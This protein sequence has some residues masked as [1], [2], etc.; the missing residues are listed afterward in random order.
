MLTGLITHPGFYGVLAEQDGKIVGSNFLDE[1]TSIAG[2]GPITIATGLQNGNIGKELMMNVI[3][4][5]N[6]KGFAGIRLLQ[7]A[8]NNKSLS[9]YAKLG[10]NVQTALAAM[11]GPPISHKIEGYAVRAALKEDMNACNAVC[12]YVHGHNRSGE[13]SDAIQ[14]GTALVVEHDDSI[15]G[16]STGLAYFGHSVAESNEALKALISA[17]DQFQGTG[18][19]VPITNHELFRWCLKNKLR[20]VHV[21]TLMSIGLYNE[22]S[23]S[24]L[25]SILY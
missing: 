17:V 18:I 1:R 9:L 6:E 20:V 15:V 11:Q 7:A 23:G 8:Y 25:P 16:Y 19:L 10:F 22:P 14:Q 21:M 13:L 24:Y 2:V 3:D 12:Q 4:R 5:A